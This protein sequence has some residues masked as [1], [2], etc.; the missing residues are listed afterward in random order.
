MIVTF[1]APKRQALET[2][3]EKTGFD[4]LHRFLYKVPKGNVWEWR[5]DLA[6]WEMDWIG[7]DSLKEIV[8]EFEVN[9]YTW[10]H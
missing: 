5:I 10:N 7:W 8:R 2:F 4:A 1:C 3:I 9:M 6:P